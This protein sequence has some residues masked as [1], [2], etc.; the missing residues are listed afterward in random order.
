MTVKESFSTII[1]ILKMA[2]PMIFGILMLISF[3]N[4]IFQEYYPRVFT[5]NYFLDPIL[6]ALAGSIAFGIPITSYIAGGELLD[7]G[8]S[9]LAVTAFILSWTTVG[10]MMLPLEAKF[11]G[12]RFAFLRNGLNFIN[13]IVIAIIVAVILKLT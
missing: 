2:V 10:V 8:V 5:G 9:L 11:L 3:L 6:G 7:K 12:R 13:S 1:Q 4:P